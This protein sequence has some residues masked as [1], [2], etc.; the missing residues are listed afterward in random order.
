MSMTLDTAQTVAS[1]ADRERLQFA[2]L[3]L[4]HFNALRGSVRPG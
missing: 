4:R 2:E 1:A 3:L